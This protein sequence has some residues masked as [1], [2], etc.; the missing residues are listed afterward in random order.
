VVDYETFCKIRDLL[1]RQHLSQAQTAREL[2]LHPRTI[3]K[4]SRVEQF[5][6]R[7]VRPRASRLDPFKGRIVRWLDTHPYSAQQILQRLRE[8]GFTGGATIVKDYVHQIRPKAQA[9][10]LKLVFAPG[11]CAQVDWGVYGTIGVGSTRRALSFFVMVLCYSRRMYL[12]FTVSQSTELFLG[13]HEHAFQAMGGVPA[14][15]MVDNLK[16][17]VLQRWVGQA[18]VFNPRYLD[19][20]RHWGFEIAPCNVRKANE[21]ECGSCCLLWVTWNYCLARQPC[22][23]GRLWAS[24]ACAGRQADTGNGGRRG[25]RAEA[26][27]GSPSDGW[28]RRIHPTELPAPR[29]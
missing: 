10:F 15:V 6:A 26:G 1:D 8:E 11:E 19:F 20:A 18:P 21:K 9:A 7:A 23:V 14:R 2:G 3:W 27:P 5:R 17:A 16:S 29:R 24:R 13:C 12:E 22:E 25:S 4:W 28:W